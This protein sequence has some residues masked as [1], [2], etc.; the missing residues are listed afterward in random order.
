MRLGKLGE[1]KYM[2]VLVTGA[3]GFIGSKVVK[4]LLDLN[5]EVCA[6]DLRNDHVDGRAVYFQ[7][8]IFSAPVDSFAYF[9]RPDV[10]LHL[11]WRD[12]FVHNSEAH[13]KDLKEHFR[14]LKNLIDSGIK[15]VAVMGT[16]HE[17]GFHIGAV[18]ENT[19]CNPL[20]NYGIA[21]NE[22]RNA[23]TAYCQE[24]NVLLQWLRAYYILGDEANGKS[25][26][27]KILQAAQKG[28]KRFPF[29][30]GIKENDFISLEELTNQI[31][32][33][34]CQDKVLGIINC[35]SGK[36]QPLKAVAE[37]FIREH[38]LDIQLAYGEFPDR[39]YDSSCIYGDNTKIKQIMKD[40]RL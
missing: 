9:G 20:S 33:C 4:K 26:F 1:Q 40:I 7:E 23:L 37:N 31:V 17:V 19:P 27:S 24:K 18:D 12:G 36:P 21:K 29:V 8:S 38:G 5:H 11:A 13:L 6:V 15:R 39:P 14:F 28:E 34:I 35:C 3:N 2:R 30:S 25:V 10:C 22:L 16:M 32:A